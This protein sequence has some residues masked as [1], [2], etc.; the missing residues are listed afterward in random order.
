MSAN[1]LKPRSCA[2]SRRRLRMR[3][4]MGVLS[5]GPE[6]WVWTECGA[7]VESVWGPGVKV[8]SLVGVPAVELRELNMDQVGTHGPGL[9]QG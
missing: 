9:V 4:M 2:F 1:V 8:H 7:C 5:I 6:L 3:S